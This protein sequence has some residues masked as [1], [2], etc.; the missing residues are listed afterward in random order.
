MSFQSR[1]VKKYHWLNTSN[2]N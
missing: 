1:T 2:Q